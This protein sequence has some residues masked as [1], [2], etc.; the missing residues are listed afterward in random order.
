MDVRQ[1]WS[2]LIARSDT[3][4]RRGPWLWLLLIG[5]G[6]L[7]MLLGSAARFQRAE[8][9]PL[10]TRTDITPAEFRAAQIVWKQQGLPDARYS[11]GVIQVPADH[12]DHYRQ[13]WQGSSESPQ[14]S[15]WADMWQQA[16]DRLGHFSGTRERDV[17]RDISRAQVVARLLEELPDVET[18]DIVWDEAESSG[19]R[20]PEQARAT[21]Y[22]KAAAGRSIGP[23]VV[24]AVR[25][26]VAGSKAHLIPENVIVMDQS[27]MVAWGGNDASAADVR[28]AQLVALYRIRL[29]SA[30]QHIPAIQVEIHAN[31]Q[32]NSQNN[33]VPV[34]VGVGIPDASIRQLAGLSDDAAAGRGGDPFQARRREVFRTVEQHLHQSITAK[35]QQLIP[36]GLVLAND[37]QLLV[38]TLP[39]TVTA[40]RPDHQLQPSSLMLWLRQ[41]ALGVLAVLCGVGALSMFR[42][43]SLVPS[44]DTAEVR[45]VGTSTIAATS[46]TPARM[47][48]TVAA[49][50]AQPSG[51]ISEMKPLDAP[52]PKDKP[53]SASPDPRPDLLQD[54][55]MR[56]EP[57]PAVAGSCVSGDK[58][59]IPVPEPS[60][61]RTVVSSRSASAELKP[62]VIEDFDLDELRHLSDPD[63]RALVTQV[64]SHVWS[65]ALFAASPQLRERVLPCLSTIEA[66]RV[67]RE[68]QAT[69]PIRL[70]EI[71]AAQE[72]IR[73]AW[74]TRRQESPMDPLCAARTAPTS[75]PA[76]SPS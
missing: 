74:A 7:V 61:R 57:L 24:D 68:L 35:A 52:A 29:Q 6:S 30:L 12:L 71:D 66:Q 49:E 58:P 48:K 65:R 53:E 10:T 70:R 40:R 69:R 21:I 3:A 22:L 15:R 19:W 60:S 16:N 67:S 2:R 37:H 11:A 1:L 64:E 27:R 43:Q 17:A 20:T 44:T 42:T 62:M 36:A 46:L 33:A 8:R 9:V 59:A 47:A 56:L 28:T 54:V 39:P 51:R 76:D 31:P 55:L 18:A 13:S 4:G 34:A 63:L 75:S 14:R 73:Q 26:A 23:D 38:E 32:Q 25:K 41:N 5:G 72:E 45:P 50:A